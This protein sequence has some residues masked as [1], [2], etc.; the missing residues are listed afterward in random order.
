[1][2]YPT[3][4]D[5]AKLEVTPELIKAVREASPILKALDIIW[6]EEHKPKASDD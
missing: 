2:T 3:L 6:D 1:M 4:C 5:L